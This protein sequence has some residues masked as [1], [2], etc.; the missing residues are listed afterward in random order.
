MNRDNGK[1][2]DER[3]LWKLTENKFIILKF[4]YLEI[5]VKN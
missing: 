2:R 1:I 4:I 3:V 5:I